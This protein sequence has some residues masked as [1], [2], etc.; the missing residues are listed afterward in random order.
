VIYTGHTYCYGSE[1]KEVTM[2][3]ACS[4]DVQRQEIHGDSDRHR[5]SK[6][7]ETSWM[8]ENE[9]KG[10]LQGISYGDML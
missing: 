10:Q 9:V 1:I 6:S 4:S 8:V 5:E 3:W 2:D 7:R